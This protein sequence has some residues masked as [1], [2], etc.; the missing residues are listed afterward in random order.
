MEEAAHPSIPVEIDGAIRRVAVDRLADGRSRLDHDEVAV[1][2]P[3]EIQ[4][5]SAPLV[6]LMRT[7][8]HDAE[9]VRGFLVSEGVVAHAGQIRSLRHCSLAVDPDAA[10]NVIRV[11]LEDGVEVDLQRLRRNLHASSSCGICGKAS[12]ENVLEAAAPLRDDSRFD[13]RLLSRLVSR[14][15]S[16]QL[17]FDRTGGVHAAGLVA[18]G[19][20]LLVVREDVGRHNAV[21]KVVGWALASGRV[22]LAGHALVV[23]GRISFEIAQKALAARIPLLAAVSAPTSLAVELAEGAGLTLVGFLRGQRANVYGLRERLVGEWPAAVG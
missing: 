18:P 5:G 2:E 4:L 13:M 21:D 16:G 9:L 12:I 17:L 20:E 14:L 3:L 6:V 8:G 1:E 15:R 10:D 7:P 23:S 19:G 22:P 11:Q